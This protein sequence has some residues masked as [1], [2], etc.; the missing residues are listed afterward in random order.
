MNLLLLAARNKFRFPSTKGVLTFEQLW[1]L[2][3]Q[4]KAGFSLDNVAQALD[5]EI[6]AAGR[7]SFVDKSGNPAKTEL[8]AKLDLVVEVINAKQAENAAAAN[9]ARRRAEK[10]QLLEILHDK[11]KSELLGLSAAEIEARIAALEG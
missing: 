8:Q 4:S 3:L 11:K 7:T 2:P 1:D 9:S 5:A 6:Q 10:D